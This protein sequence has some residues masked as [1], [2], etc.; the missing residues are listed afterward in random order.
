M[1][2]ERI[3]RSHSC[4]GSWAVAVDLCGLALLVLLAGCE[5]D[6][7]E[8][9]QSG[10]VLPLLGLQGRWVGQ[11]APTDSKCGPPTWGLM[12]IGENSFGFD[13]F[14]ST[15]VIRG[16][17]GKDGH[18]SGKLVRQGSEHQDLSISFDGVASG[19]ETINGTLQSN[20]C[21]WT[22]TLRRG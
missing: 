12:T 19:T 6:L 21:R 20:R 13:P 18:L 8:Q 14:Q 11:V 10:R 7:S 15:T 16:Q 5:G 2:C 1:P 3:T 22:V 17:V 9:L 4:S